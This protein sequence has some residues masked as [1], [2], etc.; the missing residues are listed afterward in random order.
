MGKVSKPMDLS[1]MVKEHDR[2]LIQLLYAIQSHFNY[3][4]EAV[5]RELA[6]LLNKPL[7]ELYR[8]VTFYKVFSLEPR[9]RHKVTVCTGTACHVRGS[10][11][12]V[13]E[14]SRCLCVERGKTSADGEY[15]L[16]TVNC[17]G[18]CA[19]G[20]LAEIDGEYHGNL[21]KVELRKILEKMKEAAAAG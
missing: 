2:S 1:A 17:L 12:I 10:E 18:A 11:E 19:L 3:L 20:P 6:V 7:M 14:V 13:E 15:T 4:P 21:N 16:E 8:I 5:L 9:G